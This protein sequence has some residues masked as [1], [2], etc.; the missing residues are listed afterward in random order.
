MFEDFCG[1]HLNCKEQFFSPSGCVKMDLGFKF[2]LKKCLSYLLMACQLQ[3]KA[4]SS[5]EPSVF[6]L[7]LQLHCNSSS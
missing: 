5:F 4:A 1:I 6:G 7:F 3:N 2:S